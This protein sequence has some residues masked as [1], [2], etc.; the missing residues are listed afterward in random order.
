VSVETK[1]SAEEPDNCPH[2]KLPLEI[3]AVHIG[4]FGS[5]AL[6]VCPCCGWTKAETRD[7]ARRKLGSRIVA[8][9]RMLRELK[10]WIQNS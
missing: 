2:C 9:E 6:F 3:A 10:S 1:P 8:L 4:M 7:E 5:V